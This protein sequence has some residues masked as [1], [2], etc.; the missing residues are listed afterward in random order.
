M[1]RAPGTARAAR[2]GRR[3]PA[4]PATGTATIA[5]EATGGPPAR[6]GAATYGEDESLP[7]DG[8]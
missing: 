6:P 2:P 8:A 4:M 7:H 5:I 1:A 3:S